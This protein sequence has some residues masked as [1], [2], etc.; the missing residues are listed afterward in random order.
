MSAAVEYA[1][2]PANQVEV[3]KDGE[4]W[5]LIV[6]RELRHPPELVWEAL[7]DP[8]Q[9]REW[10]PFEVE[11]DLG[12]EGATV[13]LTWVGTG[14][15]TDAAVKRADPPRVLEFQN[16]RWELEPLDGGTRLTLWHSIPRNYVAWGAAGWQISLDV[17][18]R[19]LAGARIGRIAGG[20]AMQ[21]EGWRRLVVEYAEQFGVQPPIW[22]A[23]KS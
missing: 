23:K 14:A 22:G 6:T 13:K 7:I 18:E 1:P 3:H 15:V 4:W 9:L 19:R 20:A 8:E 21:S 10:A 5:T 11:G 12:T 16:L 2:G 17:L